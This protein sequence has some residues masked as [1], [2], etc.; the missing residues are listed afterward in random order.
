[1]I[2]IIGFFG[3]RRREVPSQYR[4]R[5]VPSPYGPVRIPSIPD[6]IRRATL[7]K[8]IASVKKKQRIVV[9]RR[10][11]L[12][13]L[14]FATVYVGRSVHVISREGFVEVDGPALVTVEGVAQVYY[15]ETWD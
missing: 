2:R 15:V 8:H 12:Y 13:I 10:V 4:R 3:K 1:M 11:V 6:A 9:L 7:L 5:E 14:G